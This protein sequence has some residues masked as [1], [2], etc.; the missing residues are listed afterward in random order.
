VGLRTTML[1]PHFGKRREIYLGLG[2]DILEKEESNSLL[3]SGASL[4]PI[5]NIYTVS[6]VN[7]ICPILR[8]KG[9]VNFI[10][11]NNACGSRLSRQLNLTLV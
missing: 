9:V 10:V 1:A 6:I 4:R 8:L 11:S 7:T 3:R 2:S 5:F